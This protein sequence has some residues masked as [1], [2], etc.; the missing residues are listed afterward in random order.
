MR[1][2]LR[3]V[4]PCFAVALLTLAGLAGCHRSAQGEACDNDSDCQSGLECDPVEH[5]CE[6][7]GTKYTDSGSPSDAAPGTDAAAS[8]TDAAPGVDSA[9]CIPEGSMCEPNGTG[10]PCCGTATCCTGPGG[11]MMPTCQTVCP[12]G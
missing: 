9:M 11:V 7:P 2:P 12:I 4:W 8:S 10:T 1:E 6:K 3:F 5:V